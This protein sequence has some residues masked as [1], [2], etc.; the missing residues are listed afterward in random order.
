[1]KNRQI[2]Y[3][4]NRSSLFGSSF[5]TVDILLHDNQDMIYCWFISKIILIIRLK[6]N[7]N[8]IHMHHWDAQ[9][10]IYDLDI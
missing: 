1:M 9:N 8:I 2:V 4:W 5:C 7:Y 3:Y 6:K 10:S